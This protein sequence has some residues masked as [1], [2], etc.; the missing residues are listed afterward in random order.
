MDLLQQS[1]YPTLVTRTLVSWSPPTGDGER[2]RHPCVKFKIVVCPVVSHLRRCH[3]EKCI[4][5]SCKEKAV[6]YKTGL[7]LCYI[8]TKCVQRI[9]RYWGLFV[10][11]EW[12]KSILNVVLEGLKLRVLMAD[13][14]CD[15][16]KCMLPDVYI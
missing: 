11:K 7:H 4:Y 1:W 10:T 9:W 15:T 6:Q 2:Q 8:F 5:D 13:I 14:C 12:A 16:L 3:H